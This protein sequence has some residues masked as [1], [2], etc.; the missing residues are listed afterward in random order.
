[1]TSTRSVEEGR[2]DV[3]A[4]LPL[5]PTQSRY[6]TI[7][8]GDLGEPTLSAVF[9]FSAKAEEGRLEAILDAVYRHHEALR[10]RLLLGSGLPQQVVDPEANP[11]EASLSREER[12]LHDPKLHQAW[13][14]EGAGRIDSRQGRLI[15]AAIV[16]STS[17]SALVLTA[18]RALFDVPSVKVLFEDIGILW[19]QSGQGTPL[20]LPP[21]ACAFSQV[22][23]RFARAATEAASRLTP[24]AVGLSSIL[25][26]EDDARPTD[27]RRETLELPADDACGLLRAGESSFDTDLEDL[28]LTI[29][30]LA[31]EGAFCERDPE[32]HLE[33][34]ARGE[35]YEGCDNRRLVGNFQTGYTLRF[36]PVTTDDLGERV[37]RV[38]EARRSVPACRIRVDGRNARRLGPRAR[39]TDSA[40]AGSTGRRRSTSTV[41]SSATLRVTR[42]G[43]CRA[44]HSSSTGQRVA[45]EACDSSCCSIRGSS[46]KTRS[47]SCSR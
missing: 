1:M 8:G 42:P 11:L 45:G 20:K 7:P 38:R 30:L 14:L 26:R 34:S 24:S 35:L 18:H 40:S 47:G 25:P 4:P 39:A 12:D 2:R 15:H 29:C 22:V 19:H 46:R 36:P 5:L 27:L 10:V 13:A 31:V 44:R 3:H 41:L 17:Q 23:E 32:F 21:Q 37:R 16:H 28:L 43:R 33:A 6:L 9:V